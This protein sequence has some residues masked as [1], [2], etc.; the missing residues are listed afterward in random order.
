M[1]TEALDFQIEISA[2]GER[3]YAVT[4]RAPAEAKQPPPCACR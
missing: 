1:A 3:G 2:A 4:A